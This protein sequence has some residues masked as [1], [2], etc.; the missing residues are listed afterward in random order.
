MMFKTKICGE[1]YTDI[2]HRQK[3]S[4]NYIIVI[5]YKLLRCDIC[6]RSNSRQVYLFELILQLK[7]SISTI[8]YV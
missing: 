5:E 1:I 8:L 4:K 6:N 3:F 7:I 2:F